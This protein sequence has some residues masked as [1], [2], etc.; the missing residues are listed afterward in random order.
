MRLDFWNSSIVRR[1]RYVFV[2]GALALFVSVGNLL[3]PID[4]VSWTFQAKVGDHPLS[5]DIVFVEVPETVLEDPIESDTLRRSID[6]LDD[7]G[8]DAIYLD[9]ARLEPNTPHVSEQLIERISASDR[10]FSVGRHFIDRNRDR[11]I[12][13]SRS[14]LGDAKRVV[15]VH[16]PDFLG[17]VWRVPTSVIVNG[18]EYDS[19]SRS[20]AGLESED[21]IEIDYHFDAS[22]VPVLTAET[23]QDALET[24]GYAVGK[25]FVFGYPP[26]ASDVAID[27]PGSLAAPQSYVAI[28]AAETL[29]RGGMLRVGAHLR[30][31]VPF[32]CFCI[33]TILISIPFGKRSRRIGY[34]MAL[35]GSI[36]VVVG[37]IFLPFRT[38]GA[39]G[40]F[41]LSAY[42]LQCAIH[43]WRSRLNLQSAET[44]L[45]TLQRL[46]KDIEALPRAS[47][48]VLV[49]AKL[50][51]FSEVMATLP[52]SSKVE[53]F[54][55]VVKRLRVADTSLTVYSNGSD[56]LLWLQEFE[57][58]ETVR[59][60]LV[61]L[62]SIFKSPLRL[63]GKPIDISI[64]CGADFNFGGEGHRRI[65]LAEALTDKT[66]LSAQPI[67]FGAEPDG[68][69]E[70]WQVS[71]QSKIDAALEANEIYPVFQPQVAV[72]GRRIVGF[73]GLVRWNDSKRGLISPSYFVEQCEQAG[74]MEKLQQFMLRE[75]IRRF[76]NSSALQTDAWLSINVSATLLADTWL[77]QLV[78]HVLDETGFPAHRLVLEITETAKIHDYQTA[79]AVLGALAD[80]GVELSLDDFG[81]GSAGLENFFRLPFSEL[82]VDRLFTASVTES[83]KARE[84]VGNAISLG[85]SLGVRVIVEGVEDERT[86]S[87]LSSMGCEYA[88]GFLF[89]KPDYDL[90]AFET[91]EVQWLKSS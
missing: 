35:A 28:F 69:D 46:E 88:Q 52:A 79:S 70:E 36:F 30:D 7:A 56:R 86:L 14:V 55:T 65:S 17:F 58:Q 73:E 61:A 43:S 5:G 16:E 48:K 71:L 57:T 29:K 20:L 32:L 45:P 63:D 41:F 85:K 33:I 44:G 39:A 42:A 1:I 25:A 19:F 18:V 21:S 47:R 80:L 91:C 87:I 59:S 84:I 9:L 90:S 75:C 2:A 31:Y 38:G 82:K 23:V 10:V 8:A 62:L 81:T 15:A 89:G 13:P 3:S 76:M 68:A 64:T 54:H 72:D 24:E 22:D 77:T 40:Y 53:Y 11:I 37:P 27:L 83:N 60:H 51:N 50:H 26:G 67:L 74:R 4:L 78:S 49:A 34:A 12:F 66:S 6:A